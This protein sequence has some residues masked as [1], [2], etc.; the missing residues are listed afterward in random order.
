MSSTKTPRQPSGRSLFGAAKA[1]FARHGRPRGKGQNFLADARALERIAALIAARPT[2][3]TVEIGGGLGF[4][5]GHLAARPN[6]TVFEVDGALAAGLGERWPEVALA[7]DAREWEPAGAKADGHL[8][9]NIP[10]SLSGLALGWLARWPSR[11]AGAVLLVQRE[12]AQRVASEPGNRTY[13]MLSGPLQAA[14]EVGVALRVP[15][16]AFVPAP[17]VESAVLTLDR[18]GEPPT[19]LVAGAYLRLAKVAFSQRRKRAR[20]LLAELL[21]AEALAEIPK[22][23]RAEEIGPELGWRLAAALVAAESAP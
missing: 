10:Y 14:Y 22:M 20:G 11:F 13:G 8:C 23:A 15:P 1:H 4:L 17:K 5:T 19:D 16:G 9:G 7:G 2:P 3:W 18:R 21:P 12:V 6:L